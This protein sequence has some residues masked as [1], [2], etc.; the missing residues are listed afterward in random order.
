MQTNVHIDAKTLRRDSPERT[1]GS[2]Y[3]K[4]TIEVSLVFALMIILYKCQKGKYTF[5]RNY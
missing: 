4:R 3:S 5:K 2:G 1:K